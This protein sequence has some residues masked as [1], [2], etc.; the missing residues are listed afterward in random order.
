VSTVD[1]R[2]SGSERN[3][4]HHQISPPPNMAACQILLFFFIPYRPSGFHSDSLN[5]IS[6]LGMIE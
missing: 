1:I 2:S 3:G 6:L 4:S 5:S